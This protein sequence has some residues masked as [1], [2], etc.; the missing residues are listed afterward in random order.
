MS[1]NAFR[2]SGLAL[3]CVSRKKKS[4][5]EKQALHCRGLPRTAADCRGAMA[6]EKKNAPEKT[7]APLPRTAADCRCFFL[8]FFS[9]PFFCSPAV[10]FRGV[11]PFLQSLRA[12][13]REGGGL[14]R[15]R[16]S[17]G[18]PGATTT[19]RG[20]QPR[21]PFAEEREAVCTLH[22]YVGAKLAITKGG[23]MCKC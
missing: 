20:R 6:E 15:P 14:H 17:H 7:S 2:K 4:S 10:L 8:L 19:G 21:K 1:R 22:P 5:G 16:T 12:R 13:G 3:T 9:G 23:T 18:A 11:A